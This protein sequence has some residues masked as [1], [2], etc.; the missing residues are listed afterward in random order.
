MIYQG[1]IKK[2]LI[3]IIFL[4]A[5]LTSLIGYGSFVY[6]YMEDQQNRT[7]NIAK[8]VGL[9]LGQDVAKLV[10]LNEISAAADITSQL[11]SFPKLIMMVLYNLDKKALFQYS[12]KNVSF[13]V[14]PLPPKSQRNFKIINNAL[15]LYIDASYQGTHLG[16][17]QLEIKINTM[18]DL[19]KKN[20][21]V[22]L[23][24]LI[25]ILLISYLLAI[26]YAKQFTNPILTLVKFLEKIE[27]VSSLKGRIYTNEKNE[28][29]KLYEEVNTMLDRME[30]SNKAQ[31][32]ASVAFETQS[33]M[34][35][36]DTNQKIL[37]INSAFTDITGFTS[38]EVIGKNPSMLSSGLHTKEFYTSMYDNLDKYHYWSGEIYNKHKDGNIFPEH[39][40]IQA[41]LD[42]EGET[43]YYVASFL[44]LSLQKE[45]EE[46]LQHLQQY[47]ALTGLANRD[48]LLQN[49]Q[50]HFNTVDKNGWGALIYFN[51]KDFKIINNAYGYSTGDLLLQ[52]IAKRVQDTFNN[53][54]LIARI[55]SDEFALWFNFL[56]ENKDNAS[57]ESQIVAESLISILTQTFNFDNKAINTS[58]YVG[59]SLYNENDTD[60]TILLKHTHTALNSAKN[61]DKDIAFFDEEAEK[62]ALNYANIHSQLLLAIKRE[63]FSLWYQLQY[64][65]TNEIYGAEALI[66]WNHLEE[67]ISPDNFIPVAERTGLIIPI[68]LWVLQTACRQLM[69]WQKNSFTSNFIIA[70]N[71]SAKQFN[72]EYFVSQVEEEIEKNTI[73]ANHLKLELTESVL[74]DNSEEVTQKMHALQ[75][76]GVQISLDDFGT[77]YSSLQYLKNLPLNQVKIDQSFVRNIQENNRGDIAIIKSVLLLGDALGFE[78]I[79]EGVETKEQY[80]LLKKLGCKLFQGYYFARP[81]ELQHL[82]FQ[83]IY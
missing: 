8:T 61:D 3:G 2:R 70:I 36:T 25:F 15:K 76:L 77:G 31:K 39:L 83:K 6:W 68:G 42:E 24:I 10:L 48:L 32:I 22:L 28:Y 13:D 64:T 75:K 82:K 71:I 41:V 56:D 59:I 74:I 46:K 69:L 34:T 14:E 52:H 21:I 53:C 55:G 73:Q 20:I 9:V 58:L 38:Q 29:G 62:M 4:I 49:I 33:G 1:S 16:Y 57:V 54:Q 17:I 23:L 63:E 60:A 30:Q 26:F 51:L 18:W 40:T 7:I 43:I 27:F 65:D 80:I 5:T 19:I 72:Q 12:K 50:E 79:V 11:K 81:Q 47:D 44:D 35:I 45:T 67:I 66:R 37:Q 78:V